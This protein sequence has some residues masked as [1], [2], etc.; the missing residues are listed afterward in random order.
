[1]KKIILFCGLSISTAV[2]SAQPVSPHS[3]EDS[4]LGWMKVYNF[5]GTKEPLKVDDKIYSAA[6]LSI[7]DSIANWIQASYMPKG[8]LG[9]VSKAVSEK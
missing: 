3:I 6:Q 2:L 7:G 1:M 4:V 9:D 5:K 8:G